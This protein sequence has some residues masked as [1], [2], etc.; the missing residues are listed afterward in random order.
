MATLEEMESQ[1]LKVLKENLVALPSKVNAAH[2]V[3]LDFLAFQE[4]EVL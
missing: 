4:I 1:D 2:L 3:N